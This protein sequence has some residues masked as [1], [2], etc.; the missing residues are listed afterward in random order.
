MI[1]YAAPDR[2]KAKPLE[3]AKSME[4]LN[5]KRLKDMDSG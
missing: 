1:S 2:A 3:M 4:A 5:Q